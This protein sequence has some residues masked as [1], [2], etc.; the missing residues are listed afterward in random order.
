MCDFYWT[1]ETVLGPAF[2]AYNERGVSAIMRP[3]SAS[4]FE[5]AYQTHFHRPVQ[6]TTDPP[7]DLAAAVAAYL[8]GELSV[9][10][11]RRALPFDLR[12]TTEFERAVL[13]KTFEIPY[14]EVRSY[15]WIAREVG[16]PLAVR[17]VGSAVGRNPVPLL[18]P[19]HRV[20]RRDGRIGEYGLGGTSAKRA[21]LSAE[22][23][24]PDWLEGLAR[25]GIRYVGNADTR[26]YCFP[27]CR[28]VRPIPDPERVGFGSDDEARALGYRPCAVCRPSGI[29]DRE[30]T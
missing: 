6:P 20:V 24:A 5:Q 3:E 30:A 10:E 8:G 12:G 16:H 26:V 9:E 17:A 22:G 23:V 25:A 19:C 15:S 7:A 18:I 29:L 28:Q 21:L 13:L 4:E 1:I 27:T 14:G 2:I 11:A